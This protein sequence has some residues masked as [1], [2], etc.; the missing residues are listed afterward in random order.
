MFEKVLQ[1]LDKSQKLSISFYFLFSLIIVVFELLSL[2][3]IIPLVASILNPVESLRYLDLFPIELN[4]INT[5]N[6]ILYIFLIF[7]FLIILKNIT[8]YLVQRYQIRFI[9]EY[10]KFLQDE[11]FK[12]YLFSPISKLLNNNISIIN[13]NVIDLSSEYVNNYL[14]P[15]ITILADLVLLFFILVFL[16]YA[17]PVITMSS[18]LIFSVFGVII[19]LINKKIL[20]SEGEKYKE[21]KSERIKAIN[22]TFGAIFEIK[23]FNREKNFIENFNKITS[24]LKSIQMKLSILGFIPKLIFEVF[25][26]IIIT[27]FFLIIL[28]NSL[29]INE[30]L[31]IVALFCYSIVKVVPIINKILVNSQRLKYTEPSFKEIFSVMRYTLIKRSD[32]VS[33]NSFKDKIE[34][35][36]LSFEYLKGKKVLNNISIEIKKNDFVGITGDS[37]SGK[38]TLLKII[39]GLLEPTN[40]N[41]LCD[42]KPIFQN[43]DEWQKLISFV[44]QDVYI[45]DETFKKNITI[46]QKLTE[47]ND[48]K[49]NSAI[50][51]ANLY[52]FVESLPN[53]EE[54]TL[55]DK[56]AKISGG[57]KQ[58]IGLARAIYSNSDVIVLD[59]STS[60]IDDTNEL[61]ILEN[62]KQ[63][64]KLNKTI[65]FVTHKKNLEKFFDEFYYLKNNSLEKK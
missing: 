53:K 27:L 58:R 14:N 37:G 33:V 65:I 52:E 8:L 17:E 54:T 39:L 55:G 19:F 24:I 20:L 30:A 43:L 64:K 41:I 42:D 15:L 16:F 12:R 50:K 18:V 9:A 45:L 56:G 25:A 29:N 60:S 28:R 47:I 32:R 13:R 4:M 62:L 7:N 23:T 51:F 31:P 63:L 6:V 36:N 61:K 49:Y 40:G 38:S 3:M 46:G 11:L 5:D 34:L 48:E 59:E 10:Q 22:Q 1:L 57:Q 26:I 2:G 35:K 44:P 21:N